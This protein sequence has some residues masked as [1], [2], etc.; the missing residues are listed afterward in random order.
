MDNS[1]IQKNRFWLPL[2]FI[3]VAAICCLLGYLSFLPHPKGEWVSKELVISEKLT[4][5]LSGKRFVVYDCDGR[6]MWESEKGFWVQDGFCTDV[7]GD[8]G[9]DL[10]LLLW[11]IG[12]YGYARPFWV[13]E[14]E[15]T[16]SQHVFL[17][18]VSEDG[19]VH[20][21]WGASEIGSE[22]K[23]MKLLEKN[24]RIILT[25]NVEGTNSLWHWDSFGLKSLENGV[26]F[27]C[28]GD[29]IIHKEIYE[30]AFEKEDGSFDF[31]YEPFLKDIQS[32]D[33]AIFQQESML[34]DDKSAVS[35]YP[36]FGS[37]IEVGEAIAEA[38]FDIA[39]CAGNHALDRGIY[40]IDVTTDFY[41]ERGMICLGVQ[42]SRE[43][44]KK[45]YRLISKKGITFAMFDFTYGTGDVDVSD[46]YPY[47][48]HYLP[49]NEDEEQILLKEMSDAKGESDFIIVFVHWGNEYETEV[50]SDQMRM[51]ELFSKG[52]AD[53]IV[54]THPHVLQ[55]VEAIDRPDG[56]ST[57]VFYSLGN[58][59]AYQGQMEETRIGGEATF[60]VEHTY[61]GVKLKTYDLKEIDA[62]VRIER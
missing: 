47:A 50:S 3:A 18:S 61:D 8:G 37:P 28:F 11:K 17:Y 13:T 22:I 20:S 57:L 21:K 24:D 52:G 26:E 54:G 34:V 4:G 48:V 15:K 38:G 42:N 39:T 44:E 14:D 19:E 2:I 36:K 51:A 33:I 30:Y 6:K 46:K 7:D 23:R 1:F 58:F 40:G 43:D 62:F 16:Y 27:V 49:R 32:A 31:L 60:T 35:G 12:K 53:I 5:K 59:R 25:E 10:I 55:K 45:P 56:L 9:M 29:N 41:A